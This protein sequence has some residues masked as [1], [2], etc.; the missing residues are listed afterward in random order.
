MAN[1]TMTIRVTGSERLRVRMW[2]ATQIMRLGAWV[3]GFHVKTQID[4]EEA[5]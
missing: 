3:A 5:G 2:C 4:I 1:C